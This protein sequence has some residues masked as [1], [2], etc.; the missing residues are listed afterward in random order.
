MIVF[1]TV[2]KKSDAA[3]IAKTLLDGKLAACVT[4]LPAGESRYRWQ[5]KLC[6]EK[7]FVLLIKTRAAAFPR[8]QRALAKIH[9]Y[10]CPEI[11]GVPI[12][13]ISK[14]YQ[15]WLNKNVTA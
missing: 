6:T 7:E 4:T 14:P 9:P 13:K 3:R 2:A 12:E 15:D 1:T 10:D 11:I 5:G 8:L